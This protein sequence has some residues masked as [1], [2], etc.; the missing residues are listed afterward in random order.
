MIFGFNTDVRRGETLY[1]VQSEVRTA[2][3]MLDTQVFVRGRCIGKRAT[4]YG[5]R[6][7]LPDFSDEQL[8]EMLKAQHRQ[9]LEAAREGQLELVLGR[10]DERTT[11]PQTLGLEWLNSDAPYVRG[12]I[13]LRVRVT[14]SGAALAG[15][16]VTTR[17][18]APGARTYTQ[19]TTNDAGEVELSV[20]MDQDVQG[21][22]SVL[23]QA[24]HGGRAAR[25]KFRLRRA[26][27]S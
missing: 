4:P 24:T 23:V 17:L 14:E 10:P 1:H 21:E 12:A 19:A 20:P 8:H 3:R 6:A 16:I 15:A 2:E 25:R 27:G 13:F 5:D 26:V 9:V 22:T 7:A 11:R 18:T